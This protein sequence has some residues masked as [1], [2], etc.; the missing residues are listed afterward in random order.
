MPFWH[1]PDLGWK[2]GGGGGLR[3]GRGNL[4]WKGRYSVKLIILTSQQE[5]EES[6]NQYSVKSIILTSQQEVEK[7]KNSD[8]DLPPRGWKDE[9]SK[10][11]SI[12]S[13]INHFDL[14]PRGRNVEKIQF[15]IA[16]RK[17]SSHGYKRVLRR[18]AQKFFKRM[19]DYFT[20]NRRKFP[21][22]HNFFC[23]FFQISRFYI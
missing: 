1:E 10:K 8:L 11:S 12:F 13:K 3:R 6:K 18:I 5:V 2:K 20:S 19:A 16:A 23:D 14:P 9:K 15:V 7:S 21:V 4:V 22:F 17:V